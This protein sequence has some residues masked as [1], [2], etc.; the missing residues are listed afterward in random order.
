MKSTK[1]SRIG[2][3]NAMPLM[4]KLFT[5]LLALTGIVLFATGLYLTGY[6][7]LLL[8][9]G[10]M[11]FY[12]ITKIFRR[13]EIKTITAGLEK[14]K[15][16]E[17]RHI[18]PV[19]AAAKNNDG[20]IRSIIDKKKQNPQQSLLD[21]MMGNA[22]TSDRDEEQARADHEFL[23]EMA[24]K[25]QEAMRTAVSG[26]SVDPSIQKK[27]IE[28]QETYIKELMKPTI[29]PQRELAEKAAKKDKN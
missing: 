23:V 27:I 3:F 17:N 9:V 29:I 8:L 10:A 15:P 16:A 14:K 2:I 24:R 28:K 21:G 11:A 4:V 20:L 6:N 18:P 12:I 13:A 19:G 7:G 5:V 26:P 1:I 25:K 22:A